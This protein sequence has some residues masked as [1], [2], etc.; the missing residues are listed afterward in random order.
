MEMMRQYSAVVKTKCVVKTRTMMCKA[1]HQWSVKY[2]SNDVVLHFVHYPDSFKVSI[3]SHFIAKHL[4][5]LHIRRI[6]YTFL[7]IHV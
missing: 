6:I 1:M 4:I 7:V 2:W 3:T 5:H